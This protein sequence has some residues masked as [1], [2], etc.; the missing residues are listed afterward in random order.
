MKP[1]NPDIEE[2]IRKHATD[3]N[4]LNINDLV[5]ELKRVMRINVLIAVMT[6]SSMIL[7]FQI[8]TKIDIEKKL[9]E[10]DTHILQHCD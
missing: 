3:P 2:I 10:V 8:Y 4:N 1:I 6:V 7:G 5:T 9:Q